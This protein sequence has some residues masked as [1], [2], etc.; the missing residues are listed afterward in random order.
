MEAPTRTDTVQEIRHLLEEGRSKP[1]LRQAKHYHKS[2]PTTESKLLLIDAYLARIEAL[3]RSGL[4]REARSL[5]D[6]VCEQ[7]APALASRQ[8]RVGVLGAALGDP[9]LLVAPLV[10]PDLSENERREIERSVQRE[11]TDLTWLADCSVLP[12]DHPLRRCA[13]SLARAFD[14]VTSG[15]VTDEQIALVDVPRRSPLAPWKTLIRAI[16]AY[17]RGDRAGCERGLALID[18][19]SAPGRLIP[20]LRVLLGHEGFGDRLTPKAAVLCGMIK[21]T[22]EPLRD[23]LEQLDV[24]FGLDHLPTLRRRIREAVKSCEKCRPDLLDAMRQRISVRGALE[25]VPVR[26]V[27]NALGKPSLKDAS[28]WRLFARASETA[29]DPIEACVYWD[30]FRLHAVDEGWFGDDGPEVAALYLHM[31]GLRR[32]V[33]TEDDQYMVEWVADR[34]RRLGEYYKD[35]PKA[36]RALEPSRREAPDLYFTTP[37][38]LYRRAG[39]LTNDAAVYAQWLDFADQSETGTKPADEA[40]EAWHDAIPTDPRPLLHLMASAE[41]RNALKKALR[42]LERAEALD[43]VNPS[44]RQARWRLWVA[45]TRR[46]LKEGKAHLAAKDL[47]QIDELTQA[48]EGDRPAVV[49]GLRALIGVRNGDE[50]AVSAARADAARQLESAAAAD[51]LI[52]S[53]A[54]ACRMR[55]QVSSITA[56]L[57]SAHKRSVDQLPLSVATVCGAAEDMGLHV[58][59]PSTWHKPL[60]KQFDSSSSRLDGLQWLRLARTAQREGH[61]RLAYA[62]SGAGLRR[63]D[64]AAHRGHLLLVRAQSLPYFEEDRKDECLQAAAAL[65]RRNRDDTLTQQIAEEARR[66]PLHWVCLDELRAEPLEEDALQAILEREGKPGTF[67]RPRSPR[68]EFGFPVPSK[69]GRR[70]FEPSLFDL[71]EAFEEESPGDLDDEFGDDQ[72]QFEPEAEAEDVPDMPERSPRRRKGKSGR[73]RTDDLDFEFDPSTIPAEILD[74]VLEELMGTEVPSELRVLIFEMISKHGTPG[75][76]VPDPRKLERDDPELMAR[77]A[78]AIEQAE[79]RGEMGPTPGTKRRP[80]RR[81]RKRRSR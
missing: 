41:G 61:D 39:R 48:R 14:A 79:I 55:S 52:A 49:A 65:A 5:L 81:R 34:Y 57:Q 80:R 6:L 58:D 60:I 1:A 36:I 19:E 64:S 32:R 63:G 73:P 27:R 56:S 38:E 40:A 78:K 4:T 31:A 15:P 62:A 51:L 22:H 72:S 66:S 76:G 28:F 71:D 24:A 9:S 18:A 45:I 54:E 29:G 3:T 2:Q 43:A 67:P 12:V 26:H 20:A 46:H 10:D 44:V 69:R 30:R 74:T 33:P 17:Y 16:A 59:I 7:S 13:A 11:V 53:I 77:I 37:I 21:E 50:A 8:M 47:A 70:P 42:Y 35:Q 23:A 75:G 68:N 25:E